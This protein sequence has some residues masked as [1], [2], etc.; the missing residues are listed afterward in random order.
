MVGRFL[1]GIGAVIWAPSERRYLLVRRTPDKDFA[2]GVWECVTGRVDQGE[3]FEDALHRE[4]REEI[5]TAVT[6][7]FIIGTTHFYR[8][9]AVPENELVGVVYHCSLNNPSAVRLNEEH[10]D[11]RWV[12]YDEARALLAESVHRSE[13]WMLNLLGRAERMHTRDFAGVIVHNR[14]IGLELG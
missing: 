4:V 9:P 7:D 6:A 2:P 14:Q 12:T 11:L 1:A 8:G 5:G 3:S 13:Q 10:D